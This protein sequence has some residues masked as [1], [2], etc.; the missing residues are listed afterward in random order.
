M[1][2]A[3]GAFA[4]ILLYLVQQIG[5]NAAL[6]TGAPPAAIALLPGVAVGALGLYLVRRQERV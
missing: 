2:L 3:L 1:R 4:A 5:T 6:L